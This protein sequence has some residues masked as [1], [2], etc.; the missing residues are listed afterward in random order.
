MLP[1]IRKIR[2]TDPVF[3]QV[4]QL[5][6][7]ILRQ[8]LG[9]SLQQED[10]SGDAE[11]DIFIAVDAGRVVGCLM[12]KPLPGAVAKLRQMA[13]AEEQQG[14]GIGRMLMNAAEGDSRELGFKKISLHA[15]KQVTAFYSGLGYQVKGE[16]FEEVTIPHLLMEKDL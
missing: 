11:D 12:R 1:E 9:L 6:E 10:L 15:R 5:R 8:P 7:A 4:Y 2:H 13:V 3:D 14:R 16:E